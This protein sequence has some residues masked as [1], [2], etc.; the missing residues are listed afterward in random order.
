[1][2]AACMRENQKDPFIN[3]HYYIRL[4]EFGSGNQSKKKCNS[5]V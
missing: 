5:Y 4:R 3:T 2:F 1:M